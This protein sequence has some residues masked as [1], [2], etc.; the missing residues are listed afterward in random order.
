M[1]GLI[2][3]E[4]QKFVK[5]VASAETWAALHEELGIP[6]SS[7][8]PAQCYPDE[9]AMGLVGVASTRL[10][11]PIPELL[12]AF[13]KHLGPTLVRLYAGVID[14]R[15]RTLDL[16]EN[17]ERMIHSAV[18]VA[19]PNARPPH[20]QCTR[21]TANEVIIVYASARK[22]CHLADG[23]IAGIAEHFNEHVVVSH[24]ACMYSGAPYCTFHVATQP[25][26]HEPPTGTSN[27]F[28]ALEVDPLIHANEHRSRQ[29]KDANEVK[30]VV[31]DSE[32]RNTTFGE[33]SFDDESSQ[34][35]FELE[36]KNLLSPPLAE[37]ELGRLGRFSIL[38]VLSRGG[39]GS[40]LHA[41]DL[42]LDRPVA[43]KVINPS[44]A[45]SE[46]AR[47]RFVR[48]ARAMASINSNHLVTVYEV[49]VVS[50]FPFIAMELLE[51]ET[52]HARQQRLKRL[53]LPEIIRIAK[54]AARGLSAIHTR[55][56]VHRDISPRNLWL[57]SISQE[58]KILDFGLTRELTLGSELTR[59]GVI[60]GTPSYMSPEVIRGEALDGRTD[61]FSLGCV[62][63]TL[64]V[65]EPAFPGADLL[66]AISALMIRKPT[67]PKEIVPETDVHFSDLLMRMI[68]IDRTQR[69]DTALEV[70]GELDAIEP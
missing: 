8:S 7:Y 31:M 44:L 41:K 56:Y 24:D 27:V 68:A 54:G 67:P 55:G 70:L 40:V 64:S 66:S 42:Q 16:L 21:T 43:I 29:S 35:R 52:V 9:V 10:A 45:A 65:G 48:E 19:D 5:Q 57:K 20:L 25:Q 6:L 63:Y 61:L 30:T 47:M 22:L 4:L 38:G 37:G 60:L 69:P 49:G 46:T 59:A 26:P 32:N 58:L 15:W 39:M 18:R 1:H 17:T 51:G 23:I 2:Y 12:R 11:V 13:G 34:D 3:L 62:L 50:Q 36:I 28:E 14:P 33:F 53:P